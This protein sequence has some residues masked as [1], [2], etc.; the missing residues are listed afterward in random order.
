[1]NILLA[2]EQANLRLAIE[3]LLNEEPGV[4]VVGEAS[5]SE[6]LRAL[7]MTTQP[8]LAILDSDL[9]GQSFTELL[10]E[11]KAQ[12][13]A[14]RLIVLARDPGNRQRV[15]EAGADAFVVKGDPPEKLIAAFREVTSRVDTT[16]QDA[17]AE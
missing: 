2:V 7:I 12:D 9:P 13:D 14:P 4:K 16:N 6:G 15:L 5:E 3:L 1:M 8:D 10:A 17:E 11:I